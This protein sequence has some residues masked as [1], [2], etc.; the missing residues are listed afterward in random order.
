MRGFFVELYR[1]LG[2]KVILGGFSEGLGF[3]WF[4]GLFRVVM[5]F[6]ELFLGW[7]F[8]YKVMIFKFLDF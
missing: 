2:F 3:L 7:V 4:L 6:D 1:V 8:D 5:M